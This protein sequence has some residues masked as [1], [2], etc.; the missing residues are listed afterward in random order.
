MAIFPADPDRLDYT[1]SPWTNPE[2]GRQWIYKP[3]DSVPMWWP[4]T[5][6]STALT[7]AKIEA[8]DDFPPDL[9]G[10]ATAFAD[11]TDKATADLPTINGPLSTALGLKA[12]TSA[13]HSAATVTG[14]GIS[15]TGQQISLDIGTGATQVAAGDHGHATLSGTNL[16]GGTISGAT[17]VD[18]AATLSYAGTRAGLQVAAAATVADVETAIGSYFPVTKVATSDVS[19]NN[20]GTGDTF[21]EDSEIVFTGLVANARYRLDFWIYISCG[22]GGFK[23]RFTLPSADSIAANNTG[24]YSTF[25]SAASASNISSGSI[26]LV[27]KGGL[28]SGRTAAGTLV[29]R[30]GTTGGT[31]AFEW[32]QNSGDASDSTRKAGSFV[33]LTRLPSPCH[34]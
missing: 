34:S 18:S 10:G 12:D 15:I 21:T 1:E 28:T 27:P 25:D 26:V 30:V 3:H 13:L 19:R 9:G 24:T 32:A 33:T 8:L 23:A 4:Y 31:M 29:F 11:L 2:D 6:P 17:T 5:A 16:S 20:S 14:N 22:A 7:W